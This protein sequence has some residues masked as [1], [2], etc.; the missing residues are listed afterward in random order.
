M[1][2][3]QSFEAYKN[4]DFT[5]DG[6]DTYLV[7]LDVTGVLGYVFV[8]VP[9]DNEVEACEIAKNKLSSLSWNDISIESLEILDS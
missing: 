3:D 1:K 8:L 4:P 5:S 2:V 7:K 6:H 9:G